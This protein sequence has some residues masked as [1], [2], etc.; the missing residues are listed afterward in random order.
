MKPVL[1]FESQYYMALQGGIN[2]IQDKSDTQDR[3]VSPLIDATANQ[4]HKGITFGSNFGGVIGNSF[5]FHPWLLNI[6]LRISLSEFNHTRQLQLDHS[7]TN[8]FFALTHV[9][10]VNNF[11]LLLLKPGRFLPNN[12]VL[13]TQFGIGLISNTIDTIHKLTT[14]T[15]L[16]GSQYTLS[17]KT[18]AAVLGLGME[19]ILSPNISFYY[20]FNYAA[21]KRFSLEGSQTINA[22]AYH[23]NNDLDQS[24][25]QAVFGIKW[26]SL[27]PFSHSTL[28][29]TCGWYAGAGLGLLQANLTTRFA[30]ATTLQ[31]RILVNN[32]VA[33]VSPDI[34]LL[35][36]RNFFT[37]RFI[38]FLEAFAA[39]HPLKT[40]SN[41]KVILAVAP[42][43]SAVLNQHLKTGPT[44]GLLFK[45]GLLLANRSLYLILG[46]AKTKVDVNLD[47]SIWPFLYLTGWGLENPLSKEVSLRA[48]YQLG[49]GNRVSDVH[50]GSA[51][52]KN[53][54]LAQQKGSLKLVYYFT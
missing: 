45:P 27:Q 35:L 24:L 43:E 3:V 53:E 33:T 34:E 41:P 2:Y 54:K 13:Y 39:Y 38:F 11:N 22:I 8:Q 15:S 40:T 36:G 29:P 1:A 51:S 50:F 17:K 14:P 4:S 46:A 10:K 9:T 25:F 48:E 28:R 12:S 7:T 31:N 32:R 30:N 42:N 16:E 23:A 52:T 49:F 21:L 18:P 5:I 44:F 37:N 47:R 6:E 20:D 19:M 26:Q